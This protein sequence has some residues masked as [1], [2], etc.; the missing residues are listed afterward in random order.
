MSEFVCRMCL[1]I[2]LYAGNCISRVYLMSNCEMLSE[3]DH[4]FRI[5]VVMLLLAFL[6]SVNVVCATVV[7]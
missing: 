6:N 7:A 3:L 1:F 4:F 2:F 5:P